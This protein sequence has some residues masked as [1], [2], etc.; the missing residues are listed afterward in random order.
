M[1]RFSRR[2]SDCGQNTP[3]P[4]SGKIHTC[5]P[6][7]KKPLSPSVGVTSKEVKDAPTAIQPTQADTTTQ[8]REALQTPT[9]FTELLELLDVTPKQLRGLLAGL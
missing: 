9:K 5:P 8:A 6:G 1:T 4:D 7:T 2:C 3:N